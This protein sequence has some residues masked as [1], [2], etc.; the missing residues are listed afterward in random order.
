MSAVNLNNPCAE[1]FKISLECQIKSPPEYKLTLCTKE[2]EDA[3]RCNELFT[4]SKR[5]GKVVTKDD[6]SKIIVKL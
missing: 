1:Y 6:I 3:K 2:I 4:K 5:Q